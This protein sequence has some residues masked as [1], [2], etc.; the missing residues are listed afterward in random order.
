MHGSPW[1]YDTHVP[2]MFAGPG[3]KPQA[4]S[5]Q[6]ATVDIAVTL[7]TLFGTTI[8]SAASGNVLVEVMP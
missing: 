1:K 5:R 4:V 2:I 7:A 3:I 6:V 8:P